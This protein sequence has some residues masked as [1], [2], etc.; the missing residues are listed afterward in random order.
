MSNK[1]PATD[2]DKKKSYYKY[3]AQDIYSGEKEKYDLITNEPLDNSLAL[4][5]QDRN[6]LFKSG[7]LAAEFGWW[8]LEDGTAVNNT[9]RQIFAAVGS[10]ML[11]VR[12]LTGGLRGIPLTDCVMPAGTMRIIMMYI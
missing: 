9:L 5:I 7:D 12:C 1:V 10:S 3:Y 2:A 8:Q 11:R 6:D 4:R